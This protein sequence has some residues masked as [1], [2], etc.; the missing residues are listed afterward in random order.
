MHISKKYIKKQFKDRAIQLNN[1]ALD[2]LEE[3]LKLFVAKYAFLCEKFGYKR[4]TTE[5]LERVFDFEDSFEKS[6]R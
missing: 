6:E 4:I 2:L 5:R 3:R 1:D